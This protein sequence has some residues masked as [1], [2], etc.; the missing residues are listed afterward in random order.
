[1][2]AHWNSNQHEDIS[3]NSS[4]LWIDRCL[5]LLLN[6]TCLAEKQQIQT[7]YLFWFESTTYHSRDGIYK[8][9]HHRGNLKHVV[10][11]TTQLWKHTVI[12]NNSIN[13]NTWITLNTKENNDI[14]ALEIEGLGS[15]RHTNV[16][17]L[18]QLM[19]YQPSPP[20]NL[21]SN[22]NTDIKKIQQILHIFCSTQKHHMLSQ[23]WIT[24]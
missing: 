9:W 10:K 14:S 3:Q 4:R 11:V 23:R 8:I 17:V 19:G 7:L 22:G 13:M 1:M 15:D 18:N 16:M 20:D 2:L 6:T 12:V 5:L 24:T 21:I